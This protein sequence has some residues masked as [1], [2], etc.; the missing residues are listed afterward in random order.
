MSLAAYGSIASVMAPETI[1]PMYKHAHLP[2][3][4]LADEALL[5]AL[6][7]ETFVTMSPSLAGC[8]SECNVRGK[9]FEAGLIALATTGNAWLSHINLAFVRNVMVL[10]PNG[11]KQICDN[12][13]RAYMFSR[14][15]SIGGYPV[16]HSVGAGAFMDILHRVEH[17]TDLR[18][19]ECLYSYM[20]NSVHDVLVMEAE[21]EAGEEAEASNSNSYPDEYREWLAPALCHLNERVSSWTLVFDVVIGHSPSLSIMATRWLLFEFIPATLRATST[22][23]RATSAVLRKFV[24]SESST[25]T[26]RYRHPY[27]TMLASQVRRYGGGCR[28]LHFRY[29]A[30]TFDAVD[31]DMPAFQRCERLRRLF[32]HDASHRVDP[33]LWGSATLLDIGL[34]FTLYARVCGSERMLKNKMS[35]KRWCDDRNRSLKTDLHNIESVADSIGGLYRRASEDE[36]KWVRWIPGFFMEDDRMDHKQLTKAVDKL[37]SSP[38]IAFV[39]AMRLLRRQYWRVEFTAF[40]KHVLASK[41]FPKQLV[42]DGLTFD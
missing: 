38:H 35:M 20:V 27:Q 24:M 33:T 6:F 34:A 13:A 8:V 22:R 9:A 19:G 16:R 21:A 26:T 31:H 4:W 30:F 12:V 7:L 18:G 41:S 42:V 17:N 29:A 11:G 23:I 2:M 15:M 5:D 32:D 28:N 10:H 3:S 14:T 40:R 39:L 1:G 25:T 36:S 37:C